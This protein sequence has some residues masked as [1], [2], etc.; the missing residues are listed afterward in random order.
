MK[1][2]LAFSL[3]LTIFIFNPLLLPAQHH[4][5]KESAQEE[6]PLKP[7]K[8]EDC[9]NA[10][11]PATEDYFQKKYPYLNRNLFSVKAS[12]N[13]M[14]EGHEHKGETIYQCMRNAVFQIELPT[15]GYI[16]TIV[17]FHFDLMGEWIPT[18]GSTENKWEVTKKEDEWK[19]AWCDFIRVV[20][21]KELGEQGCR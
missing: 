9:T 20:Y 17:H 7:V 5:D 19:M 15:H 8:P 21:P 14:I 2:I 4:H 6:N 1:K 11:L 16:Y 13:Q 12:N 10:F 3:G 18:T